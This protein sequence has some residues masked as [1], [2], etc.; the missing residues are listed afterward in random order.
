VRVPQAEDEA[1]FLLPEPVAHHRDDSRPAGGLGDSRETL[2]PRL[3]RICLSV[4]THLHHDV[5]AQ[6]VN[7][8]AFGNTKQVTENP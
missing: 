6:I 3:E 2:D 7:V 4:S 1:A 8:V 5:I